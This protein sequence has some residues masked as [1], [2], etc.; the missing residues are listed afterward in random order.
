MAI[1]FNQILYWAKKAFRFYKKYQKQNQNKPQQQ[2]QQQQQQHHQQQQQPWQQQQGSPYPPSAQPGSYHAQQSSSPYPQQHQPAHHGGYGSHDG[3]ATSTATRLL[4]W[5][6]V[7]LVYNRLVELE[8]EPSSVVRE[9]PLIESCFSSPRRTLL[10]NNNHHHNNVLAPLST[11][12]LVRHL[13]TSTTNLARRRRQHVHPSLTHRPPITRWQLSPEQQQQQ[14]QQSSLINNTIHVDPSTSTLINKPQQTY[15]P[16]N[17]VF[18]SLPPSLRPCLEYVVG[19]DMLDEK[20]QDMANAQNSEYVELRNKAI[21]EADLMGQAFSASKQAYAS[22]D[23][24]RAHDLSIQGKEHQRLKEMYNDQA[25]D[26][27]F[28]ANNQTQPFG[29]ID[30]HGLYVQEAIERTEQS[31]QQCRNQGLPELRVI[32]G[33]GIHSQR[34]V[35]KIKPAIIDLM[36]KERLTAH[37]DSH[38]AGVLIVQLQGQGTGKSSR[39]VINDLE[40]DNNNDCIVM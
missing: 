1:N 9:R 38:N 3:P 18:W 20:N 10:F 5:P 12:N 28:K 21:R 17:S 8:L 11:S 24:A 37:L 35:A 31:I 34:H 29:T 33:K 2:Q 15:P 4:P 26:W 14:Q 13:T 40:N 30:L 32:V 7:H 16:R 27:I 39:E 25:A 19:L 22:G 36:E 23:G 6:V